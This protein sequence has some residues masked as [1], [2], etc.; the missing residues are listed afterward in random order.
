MHEHSDVG[1]HVHVLSAAAHE[2]HGEHAAQHEL[3]HEILEQPASHPAFASPE[4]EGSH[5]L[6][7]FPGHMG[8]PSASSA[9][10]VPSALLPLCSTLVPP[11]PG[12]LAVPAISGTGPPGRAR[13]EKQRS[14]IAAVL[15]TSRAILI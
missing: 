4:R 5:L 10:L 14:G 12:R 8:S 2:H 11:V 1:E 7:A 3:E 9:S 13:G 6:I 15:A